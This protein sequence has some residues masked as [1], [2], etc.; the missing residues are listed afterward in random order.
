V[1]RQLLSLLRCPATGEQ[2]DLRGAPDD[3]SGAVAS[4]ELATADGKHVY[5]IVDGIPRFVPRSNYAGS[6]GLQWNRFRSTQLDSHSG[7]RIS[8]DRFYGYTGW[9]AQEL[10]G[11]RVLDVGCGAGRFTEIALE[12][13]ANVV[14]IDYS[15]AVDACRANHRDNPNLEVVQADIYALP[16]EPASFDFVYC[17]GV[18]QHTPDVHGAFAALP[19]QLRTGGR[20]AVD[21][22]PRLWRNLLWSKYWL[23]PLT[24]RMNAQ[25][26]FR[27][28]ERAVPVMLP[29]SRAIASIP[30]L[31]P[32]LR[33]AVPVANYEGTYPLS[34]S[35]LREWA[36]LDTFD[37]LA[38]AHDHPQTA[39]TLRGWLNEAGLCDVS[40]ERMGFLVGRGTKP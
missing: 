39:S 40:V 3:T 12:A 28:V 36:I 35:Q 9:K 30:A 1:N 15:T 27:A 32:K 4:G 10:A 14:A 7:L 16:F 22:Y 20:L 25:T 34:E 18:L 8:H 23:R 5:P 29:V 17:L 33:Y 37:M 26:L 6:F 21:L 38:P 11:R 19:V 31:G 13:G 2:L 24:K